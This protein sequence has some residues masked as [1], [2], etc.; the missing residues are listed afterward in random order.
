MLR[1]SLI[2]TIYV[3][4]NLVMST[5]N[6]CFVAQFMFLE[7]PQSCLT[8]YQKKP[9]QPMLSPMSTNVQDAFIPW[10]IEIVQQ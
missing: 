3:A 2:I 1:F 7:R 8:P 6:L 10:T 5:Q 9:E 4:T